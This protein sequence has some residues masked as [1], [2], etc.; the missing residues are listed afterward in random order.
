VG[1]PS[2]RLRLRVIP[3]SARPGVVGRYGDGWKVRVGAA[4]ERGRANEA[5]LDLLATTLS[6][7]R[8]DVRLVEGH[9][10]RDKV[11]QIDGIAEDETLRRLENGTP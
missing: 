6:M 3:G 7:P 10:A 1:V 8:R 9:G 5:V 4:P 11:V 2:T